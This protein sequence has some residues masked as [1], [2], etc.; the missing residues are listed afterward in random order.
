MN[1]GLVDERE[2]R[3]ES[4]L[5]ACLQAVE[6]GRAVDVCAALAGNAEFAAEVADL[7]SA[8]GQVEDV[9]APLRLL[10]P[11]VANDAE[12]TTTYTEGG[13]VALLEGENPDFG[14]YELREVLGRGG[15]GKVYRA[16]QPSLGVFVAL[17]MI[18]AGRF[19]S[20]EEVTRFREEAK[21]VAQLRH[22]HIV[23]VLHCAEHRG[24][25]FL[26]MDLM[27]GGSLSQQ[28][29]R[30]PVPARRAA[31]W[32]L[33]VAQAIQAVHEI[34]I[35]HRDLKP[36][37]VVLDSQGAAHVTDFGLA[38]CLDQESSSTA[39]GAIV[40][41]LGYMS[42]E[43]IEGRSTFASDIY[44]L[45][46]ILYALLTGRPPFQSETVMGTIEQVRFQDPIAPRLLNP[47]AHPDLER[48]CS[49]CLEKEPERRHASA[50]AVA[51]DLK[52]FLA[53]EQPR[54]T[55]RPGLM[56]VVLRPFARQVQGDLLLPWSRSN[57]MSAA[58]CVLGHGAVFVLLQAEKPVEWAFLVLGCLWILMALNVWILL[59]RNARSGHRTEGHVLATFL[60]Y[61]LA[62]PILVLS[63]GK[64]QAADLLAIYPALAL[65]T[66][67]VV[68]V[69]GSLFWGRQYLFGLAY[70]ALAI[71]MRLWPAYAP[72]EFAIFHSS[73]MIFMSRH[74][75]RQR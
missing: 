47:E 23:R 32:L 69:H 54:H 64:G 35:V 74:L 19:A 60:G 67:L 25:N 44:G 71:L 15:M 9:T 2:Q 8:R 12:R 53:G 10:T 5:A 30:G 51:E 62:Y 1:T 36:A 37:N 73:Y 17:K 24:R 65:L 4:A 70:Y 45:G 29:E 56:A 43:Q 40:G 14:D 52:D 46:G 49:K 21:K 18:L 50:A 16:F 13:G 63:P 22:P 57:S 27:E 39:P 38:K 7:F 66:G 31:Q 28:I 34:R 72:L 48:I 61:V 75:R 41:T 58:L 55:P 6:S 33:E 11:V 26:T 3:L 42:P 59:M 20:Q 68:F